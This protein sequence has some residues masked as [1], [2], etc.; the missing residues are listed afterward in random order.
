MASPPPILGLVKYM[1]VI[2]S[3][4]VVASLVSGRPESPLAPVTSILTKFLSVL[5]SASSA[6]AAAA[7]SACCLRCPIPDRRAGLRCLPPRQTLSH[8]QGRKSGSANILVSSPGSAD[9]IPASGFWRLYRIL[10][11]ELGEEQARIRITNGALLRPLGQEIR[12]Q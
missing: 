12:H 2:C 5:A 6:L 11:E 3:I 10:R 7:C 8:G 9:S 4:R 1:L